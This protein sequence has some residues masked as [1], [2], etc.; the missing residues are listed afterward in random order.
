MAELTQSVKEHG[1]LQPVLVRP[2]KGERFELVCGERRYRAA[3]AAGLPELPA[4]IRALSDVQVLEVQ[5][6]ENLQRDDLHPLEEAEGYERLMKQHGY[7]AEQIAGK[8][9]K[10]RRYVFGRTQ[11]LALLPPARKAFYDGKLNA[12]TALL[13]ARVPH[14]LQAEALKDLVDGRYRGAEPLS[15]REALEHIQ[16]TYT[17]RLADAPFK[18]S[19]AELLPTAGACGPCPKRTGNQPELFGDIKGADVCTDP[20]CFNAKR[21]AFAE[22]A[23]PRPRSPAS[24]CSPARPQRLVPHGSDYVAHRNS[25]YVRS[26]IVLRGRQGPHLRED[27]RR[28]RTDADA[29]RAPGN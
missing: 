1:V 21:T 8:V 19:D 25:G 10:S 18:T 28:R 20:S 2:L 15:Y 9:H 24:A 27:P 12:S 11:L 3:K 6:I 23:R 5:V 4:A 7:T 13:V 16:R 22:A 26:R 14:Q 29:G 17:L